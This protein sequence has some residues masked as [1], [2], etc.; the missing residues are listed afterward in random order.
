VSREQPLRP[1]RDLGRE[2]KPS[3]FG[4]E[5]AIKAAGRMRTEGRD[6]ALAEGDV[7]HFLIGP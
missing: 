2:T 1:S 4:S 7:C 5:A 6:Y 3:Q